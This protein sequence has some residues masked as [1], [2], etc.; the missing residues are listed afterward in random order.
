MI[1]RYFSSCLNFK[2][3]QAST[4]ARER[5]NAPVA[6]PPSQQ[7]TEPTGSG[8]KRT[9]SLPARPPS[10]PFQRAEVDPIRKPITGPKP[11]AVPPRT[12]GTPRKFLGIPLSF[13][14]KEERI[15]AGGAEK[16]MHLHRGA[17]TFED[18]EP[19]LGRHP[20]F[21]EMIKEK[22]PDFDQYGTHGKARALGVLEDHP[23]WGAA[24]AEARNANLSVP[25]GPTATRKM[26]R[27]EQTFLTNAFRQLNEDIEQKPFHIHGETAITGNKKGE[28]TQFNHNPGKHSLASPGEGDRYHLHTH[29]PFM[30]PFTS[31]A[32]EADHRLATRFHARNKTTTYVTNGKD[33]LHIQPHSLEL[34]KLIPDPKAEGK[35]GKFPEAFR[36]PDPRQPPHPF[37]NHEAPPAFKKWDKHK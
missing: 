26:T 25:N 5:T 36:V 34:V 37:S 8:L 27:G 1:G 35:L 12:F 30:E 10:D 28:I 17:L 3:P 29:P 9:D 11:D 14:S 13:K 18:M 21:M 20:D 32:S 4:P 6:K 22:H 2:R 15:K 33:V 24:K 16:A 31:S 7:G 23:A 19:A